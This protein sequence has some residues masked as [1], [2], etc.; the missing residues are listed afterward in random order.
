[1][2]FCFVG[3]VGVG[4]LFGCGDTAP[5]PTPESTYAC[6]PSRAEW[7]STV[8]PIVE[9]SCGSCHGSTPSYGAPYSLLDYDFI[10]HTRGADRPVDK[11]FTRLHEGTMP[12][13]GMPAP[14]FTDV[15]TIAH[16]A[17]C[18]AQSLTEDTRMRVS[19]PVFRPPQLA[20]SG[21]TTVDLRADNFAVPTVSDR[22]QCF[23]FR[24]VVDHDQFVRRFDILID[25][26][27][28]LHHVVLY[29]ALGDDHG[30]ASFECE[31][32]PEN[33]LYTYTWAP[34]QD[35]L[36]FPDGGLRVKPTDRYILQIHYNNSREFTGLRDTSG[37]R[38]SL[39]PPGGTEYGMV[40]IGPLGFS[41]GPRSQR[42]VASACVLPAGTRLLASMP[43]MH[44]LGTGYEQTLVRA[45]Q[46][47]PIVSLSHWQFTSQ[48]FYETP[49]T[50]ADGD[51]IETACTFDNTTSQT[52]VNGARTTDEMCF[53]FT[54]VTP[55]P[56][57]AYCDEPITQTPTGEV[58]YTPGMCSPMGA[59]TD[60]PMV[61]GAVTVGEPAAL[62]GGMIP[63]G[64][65]VLT[66]MEYK[67]STVATPLGAIDPGASA[68]HGR[69]QLWVSHNRLTADVVGS[70]SLAFTRGNRLDRALP[71]INFSG[72][73]T[74][75]D[76]TLSLT[77]DCT[78]GTAPSSVSYA[79]QND[80]LVI[81]LA[82]RSLGSVMITPSYTFRR[83]P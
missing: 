38:L 44:K 45:G 56:P 5:G 7:M 52:V 18:G 35:A 65:W 41:I 32:S 50:V 78:V 21:L 24:N 63:D 74:T 59:A 43:H 57:R 73:F 16:W 6:V 3:L 64:R 62:T 66:G 19:A 72:L 75:A 20:P 33:S 42:T 58:T 36:Q 31:G 37:V 70:L 83:Q 49:L 67:L 30:E 17:T 26:P 29:K 80:D 51:R 27:E 82:A 34:G 11:I 60:I 22:Y 61:T 47:S 79:L 2:R 15:Q 71:Q 1:M 39:S 77:N 25:H 46:R 40:A 69:G 76:H 81:A 53:G 4:C 23:T 14:A 13:A 68:L 28:V 10:T 8:R 48:F 12:P 54:Y 9:R 55:P